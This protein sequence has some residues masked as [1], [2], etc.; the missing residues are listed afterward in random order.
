MKVYKN[1]S[2]RVCENCTICNDVKKHPSQRYPNGSCLNIDIAN[3]IICGDLYAR[4]CG[5]DLQMSRFPTRQLKKQRFAQSGRRMRKAIADACDIV[6]SWVHGC[7]I[8]LACYSYIATFH[9]SVVPFLCSHYGLQCCNAQEH[10]SGLGQNVPALE[11]TRVSNNSPTHETQ[12][13]ERDFVYI[14]DDES[15][16]NA[17][18]TGNHQVTESDVPQF[19]FNDDDNVAFFN[20]NIDGEAETGNETQNANDGKRRIYESISF[21]H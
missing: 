20:L 11:A 6:N 1:I 17:F 16:G 14:T 19:S 4:E 12:I 5:D 10:G 8:P 15:V 2:R 3:A 18:S 21:S 9:E 13:V 7:G